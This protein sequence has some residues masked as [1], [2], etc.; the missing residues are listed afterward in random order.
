MLV[1]EFREMLPNFVHEIFEIYWQFLE[2]V[3][4][5]LIKFLGLFKKELKLQ[6]KL[7][8][9]FK[10]NILAQFIGIF[11]LLEPGNKCILHN[12]VE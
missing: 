1:H 10:F 9:W 11:E 6:V 2:N 8:Q 5:C 4:H 7:R 12:V 3:R